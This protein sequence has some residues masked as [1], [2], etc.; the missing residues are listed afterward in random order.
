MPHVEKEPIVYELWS[1]EDL[2]WIE[3]PCRTLELAAFLEAWC[4]KNSSIFRRKPFRAAFTPQERA[5]ALSI[6]VD[7]NTEVS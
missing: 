7:P 4:E 5:R 3:I 6:A 2:R 1:D